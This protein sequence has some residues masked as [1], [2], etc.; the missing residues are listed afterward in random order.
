[1]AM[2]SIGLALAGCSGVTLPGQ[3]PAP[4]AM[5]S[6]APSQPTH[7]PSTTAAPGGQMATSLDPPAGSD[8]ERLQ[9]AR[10]TCWMKVEQQKNLRG[11]DQRIA[12]VDKCVAEQSK[13]P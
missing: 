4:T 6:A 7:T 10:S 5:R 11:I 9:Q 8:A 2:I 12:F 13:T 3:Q 1:M